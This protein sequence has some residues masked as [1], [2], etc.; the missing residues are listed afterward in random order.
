[1][2]WNSRSAVPADA[3]A[4]ADLLAQLGYTLAANDIDRRL[5]DGDAAALVADGGGRILGVLGYGTR[6]QLH[7]D[8]PITSIDSLV[9]DG[10]FRSRGIGEALVNA[11]CEMAAQGGAVLVDVHSHVSRV[12]ARRFYERIGFAVTS[13]YFAKSL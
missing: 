5:A 11:V 4:I 2:A 6:W 9:V 12:D 8:G 1:M 13:N 3:A 7:K 10:E